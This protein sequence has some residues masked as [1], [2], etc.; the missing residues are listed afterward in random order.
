MDF[1]NLIKKNL[2]KIGVFFG[3]MILIL[4]V[5]VLLMPKADS[6]S[7]KDSY[8]L[9]EKKMAQSAERY[10]KK[11]PKIIPDINEE[12]KVDLQT[13]I[14]AKVIK[15][16][17]SKN[18]KDSFCTG[19][20]TA[21]NKNDLIVYKPYLKCGE[22][23][24]TT[25]IA[26]HIIDNDVIT[27]GDG[28]YKVD[29]KYIY[30]GDKPNN[31]L[32]IGEKT[33]RILSINEENELRVIN[34]DTTKD[35]TYWDNR[36]NSETKRVDG[37]NDF[38]KSRIK[39]FL[40]EYINSEEVS[41]ELKKLI[42]SKQFCIGRRALND[43]NFNGEAECSALSEELYF[44]LIQANEYFNASLDPNCTNVTTRSCSN[45][46]Y[47]GEMR[48]NIITITASSTDTYKIYEVY[49]GTLRATEARAFFNPNVVF[50]IDKDAIY[51][52]GDGT[53]SNPYRV[54]I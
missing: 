47:L 21:V 10:F 20:V 2:W 45:Y 5:L 48:N 43:T 40:K 39:D 42:I 7:S 35:L 38:N 9:I 37:I 19:E 31:Y 54:R 8:A 12:K 30:K 29:N 27:E 4:I 6:V 24:E 25:S 41:S 50:H 15:P 44:G 53:E 49:Y 11:N 13:L 22:D 23:Y 51:N 52:K 16:I 14:D 28:L 18:Q 46:N 3:V 32:K 26:K 34:P 1:A 17:K 33:F 36:Y